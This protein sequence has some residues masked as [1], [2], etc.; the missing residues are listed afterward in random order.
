MNVVKCISSKRRMLQGLSAN[1]FAIISHQTYIL[2]SSG[3]T[4]K[5]AKEM[6]KFNAK[7]QL[8]QLTCGTPEVVVGPQL[9]KR[10]DG[11]LSELV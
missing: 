4:D 8:E 1:L 7:L 3:R 11:Y 10:L 2:N 5:K 6:L 9:K